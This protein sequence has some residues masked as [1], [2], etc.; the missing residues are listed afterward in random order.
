MPSS[1]AMT[2]LPLNALWTSATLDFSFSVGMGFSILAHL[3][4]LLANRLDYLAHARLAAAD[5]FFGGLRSLL[6]LRGPH[7]EA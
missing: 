1:S 4:V 5:T 3:G 2:K 6:I 7:W